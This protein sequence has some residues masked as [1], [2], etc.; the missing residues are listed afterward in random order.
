MT[1][2]EQM[3]ALIAEYRQGG[4]SAKAFCDERQ[5]KHSTFQYW[6]QKQKREQAAAFLP[7]QPTVAEAGDRQTV[8]LVYPNGIRVCLPGFNLHHIDQLLRLR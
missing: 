7:I 8:T 6:I 1:R 3:Y 4:Q 5:I 2:Q